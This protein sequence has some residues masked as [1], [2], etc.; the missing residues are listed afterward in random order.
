MPLQQALIHQEKLQAVMT[1]HRL[2]LLSSENLTS[3]L[4]MYTST[5]SPASTFSGQASRVFNPETSPQNDP[6]SESN[7]V[8][9]QTI[10]S[11]GGFN[12]E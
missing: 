10:S 11:I 6:S 1:Q 3:L 8:L 4:H 5:P 9:A 7:S 12:V 2:S